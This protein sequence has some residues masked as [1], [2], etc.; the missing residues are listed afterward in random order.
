MGKGGIERIDRGKGIGG[1]GR[2][3]RT[4]V[5]LLPIRPSKVGLSTLLSVSHVARRV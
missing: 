1:R 4:S 3:L 2:N 5:K